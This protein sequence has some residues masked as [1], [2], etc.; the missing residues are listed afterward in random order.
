VLVCRVD[1]RIP[2]LSLYDA[3]GGPVPVPDAE[4]LAYPQLRTP[5]RQRITAS[6]VVGR[7]ADLLV[8]P[9]GTAVA[10]TGGRP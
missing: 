3:T 6:G 4:R 8:A 7:L 10:D 2:P 5:A 9:D 1:D